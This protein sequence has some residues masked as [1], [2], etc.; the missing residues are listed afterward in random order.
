MWWLSSA[1]SSKRLASA[2]CASARAHTFRRETVQ[3]STLQ[4]AGGA[5]MCYFCFWSAHRVKCHSR[6]MGHSVKQQ[7]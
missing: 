6:Q 1:V 5:C 2:S 4:T 3:K 7:R